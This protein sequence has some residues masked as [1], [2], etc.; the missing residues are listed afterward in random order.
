MTTMAM[1]YPGEN[2]YFYRETLRIS[3]NN[4]VQYLKGEDK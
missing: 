3:W 2:E 1:Q 4:N